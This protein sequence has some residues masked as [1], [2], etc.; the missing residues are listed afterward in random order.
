MKYNI[1]WTRCEIE[2]TYVII[3]KRNVYICPRKSEL[4]DRGKAFEPQVDD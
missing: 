4:K 1:L 2:K 3:K